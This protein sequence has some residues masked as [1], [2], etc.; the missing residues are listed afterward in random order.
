MFTLPDLGLRPAAPVGPAMRGYLLFMRGAG[1]LLIAL[2]V[3][4]LA[5]VSPIFQAVL[6]KIAG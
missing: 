5:K 3:L 1:L 2:T 6:G 4:T